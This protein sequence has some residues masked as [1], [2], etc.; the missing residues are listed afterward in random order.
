MRSLC[1]LHFALYRLA[2]PFQTFTINKFNAISQCY[3]NGVSLSLSQ[4]KFQFKP[5]VSYPISII[6]HHF[7]TPYP[8]HLSIILKVLTITDGNFFVID[9]NN[10][11]LFKLVKGNF[12]SRH[13]V[14]LDEAGNPIV[15]LKPKILTARDR[16]QLNSNLDVFLANNTK[17]KVCDVKVRGSW[18]ERSCV[19]YAGESSAVVA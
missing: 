9:I 4:S 19:V 18:S 14:L 5:T 8:V 1:S 15:T 6:S 17:E 13:K 11:I 7:S 16:C 2:H 3:P 10:N 12:L